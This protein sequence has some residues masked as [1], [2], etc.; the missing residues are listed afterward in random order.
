ML[1]QSLQLR[2]VVESEIDTKIAVATALGEIGAID[3]N[4]LGGSLREVSSS[5]HE[6]EPADNSIVWR[7]S[8]PPWKSQIVRYELQLVTNQLSVA[9]KASPTA[10]DQHKISFAIQEL[11][12]LLNEFANQNST[13]GGNKIDD[14]ENG[15][16]DDEETLSE[17]AKKEKKKEMNP[18]LISQLERA[19]VLELVEPFW[20][21][22]YQQVR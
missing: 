19:S 9:L 3:P 16:E 18:W 1:I 15:S 12:I 4:R 22:K 17:L 8:Q 7:W 21:T 14:K 5:G 6:L 13:D 2:C 11:L 20:S 10:M